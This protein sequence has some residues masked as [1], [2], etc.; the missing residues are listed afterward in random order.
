LELILVRRNYPKT[1]IYIYDLFCTFYGPKRSPTIVISTFL[2][3]TKPQ[4]ESTTTN[5]MMVMK[6]QALEIGLN[7]QSSKLWLRDNRLFMKWEVKLC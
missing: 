5:I 6:K 3:A 1:H 2:H 4:T 7:K